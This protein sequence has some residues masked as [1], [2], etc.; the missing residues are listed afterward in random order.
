MDKQKE[1]RLKQV[2]VAMSR[3]T[4]LVCLAMNEEHL[5]KKDIGILEGLGWS[6]VP[7]SSQRT[8]FDF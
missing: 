6:F 4:D 5:T 1:K 7:Q 2:F 3:P 8:L